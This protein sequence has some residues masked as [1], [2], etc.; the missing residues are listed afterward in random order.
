MEGATWRPVSTVHPGDSNSSL[1][2]NT[3]TPTRGP[4]G[5]IPS[6]QWFKVLRSQHLT[7]VQAQMELDGFS[8]SGRVPSAFIPENE[9]GRRL[10]STNLGDGGMGTCAC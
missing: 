8:S 1:I 6:Q 5:L 4:T 2:Q 3:P 9:E 7:Q 10:P